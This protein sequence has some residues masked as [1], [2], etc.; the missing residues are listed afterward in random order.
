MFRSQTYRTQL[1]LFAEHS[2]FGHE[3]RNADPFNAL[4]IGLPEIRNHQITTFASIFSANRV[5]KTV[6]RHMWPTF[7]FLRIRTFRT[8]NCAHRLCT[9]RGQ[10]ITA[11]MNNNND[12]NVRINWVTL[13]VID[14]EGQMREFRQCSQTQNYSYTYCRTFVAIFFYLFIY[15]SIKSCLALAI[16]GVIKNSFCLWHGGTERSNKKK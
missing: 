12:N 14:G 7:R 15:S 3:M 4:M 10:H 2:D 5:L 6:S 8:F 13:N 16:N 1:F 9:I 11:L